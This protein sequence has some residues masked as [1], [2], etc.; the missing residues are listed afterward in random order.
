[1]QYVLSR[2]NIDFWL[3]PIIGDPGGHFPVSA[4]NFGHGASLESKWDT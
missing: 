2:S 1:M 3:L 4:K